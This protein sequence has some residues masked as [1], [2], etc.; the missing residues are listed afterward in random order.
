MMRDTHPLLVQAADGAGILGYLEDPCIREI[1]CTATGHV[2][3][4]HQE[5]GKQRMP[6]IVPER[7]HP[8]LALCASLMGTE[9]RENSPQLS[10]GDATLGFRVEAS[11]PPVS[12]APAMVLRKHPSTAYPLSDFEAKGILTPRQATLLRESLAARHT[13]LIAGAIGSGKTSIL[14]ACLYEL[15]ASPE[16]FVILE[17]APELICEAA[18]SEGNRTVLAGHGHEAVTL[19]D[20]CRRVLRKSPDWIVIG[21]VRGGESLDLLK[22]FQ[23]GH[24]GLATLH[25]DSAMGTLLRLEQLN[26][27]V[28]LDPQRQLIAEAVDVI[29]HMEH[30][31][32]LFRCT[33]VLAVDGLDA[34]SGQYLTRPL[35]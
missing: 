8:F 2:F 25:A 27:E 19:R 14:N 13:I 35:I 24:P 10:M 7:L 17:D 5:H 22:A 20:L 1:R 31:G 28:S 4:I 32:R 26:L 30:H 33:G 6:D 18:D 9:W 23:V 11:M 3:A 34:A 29:F 21:E 16:R 15:R 12:L